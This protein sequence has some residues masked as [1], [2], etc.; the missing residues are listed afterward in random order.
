[1]S[2]FDLSMAEIKFTNLVYINNLLCVPSKSINGIIIDI[3]V[4][5]TADLNNDNVIDDNDKFYHISLRNIDISGSTPS[6]DEYQ[7]TVI[8]NNINQ[9]DVIS[10][11]YYIKI[12]HRYFD[13][14]DV[15]FINNQN[16]WTDASMQNIIENF[17]K[18]TPNLQIVPGILEKIPEYVPEPPPISCHPCPPCEIPPQCIINNNYGTTGMT[19]TI[20]YMGMTGAYCYMG[21]TG[22]DCYM[23]MTGAIG[24][25]IPAY[26]IGLHEMI[27]PPGM[28]GMNGEFVYFEDVP[29]YVGATGSTC[30]I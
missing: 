13:V 14:S 25:K 11:D 12:Y 1:M 23:G 19:G 18:L 29:G 7:K 15:Y 16:V 5:T 30:H 21:M 24:Y 2:F 28:T 9:Y 8:H 20:G 27:P 22:A 17:N 26:P 6:Y 3:N 10:G 4:N